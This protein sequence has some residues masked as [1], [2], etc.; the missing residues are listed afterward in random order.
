MF[1]GPLSDVISRGAP[2]LGIISSNRS[3]TTVSDFLNENLVLFWL[4]LQRYAFQNYYFQGGPHM[5][6]C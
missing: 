3:V 5:V 6:Q 1:S 2:N 4:A